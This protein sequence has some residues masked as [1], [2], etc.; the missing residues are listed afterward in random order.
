MFLFFF[1][2]SSVVLFSNCRV[3]LFQCWSNISETM[4][5]FL[6]KDLLGPR[7]LPHGDNL[8]FLTV[9]FLL[10]QT[11]PAPS[12]C[13]SRNPLETPLWVELVCSCLLNVLCSVF[14]YAMSPPVIF[15]H[16]ILPCQMPSI[17]QDSHL[18]SFSLQSFLWISRP[19]GPPPFPLNFEEQLGPVSY[20]VVLISHIWLPFILLCVSLARL[21]ELETY[22]GRDQTIWVR[23]LVYPEWQKGPLF[24]VGPPRRSSFC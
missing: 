18:V 23:D 9:K 20:N 12:T 22:C 3:F 15:S 24:L 10:L 14:A 13:T 2:K 16:W 1:P 4:Q 17:P 21:F 11:S 8:V 19:Q 5:G 6:L 7:L